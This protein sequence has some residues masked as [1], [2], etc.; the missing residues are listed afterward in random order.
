MSS[1]SIHS[2]LGPLTITEEDNSIVRLDWGWSRDSAETGLLAL[3]RDQIDEYFH[4]DRDRFRLPLSPGGTA[5]QKSVWTQ[6]VRIPFGRTETYAGLARNIGSAARAVGMACAAN[7]IP[8]LIPCHRVVGADG[9]LAGYSGG[10]G[11]ATKQFLLEHE[12]ALK[13]VEPAFL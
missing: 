2:P 5:F 1:L 6:M 13:R 3:A 9:R 10:D 12:G 8:L 7:P 11:P 4:G